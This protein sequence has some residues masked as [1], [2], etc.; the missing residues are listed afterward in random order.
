MITTTERLALLETAQE[1]F[2]MLIAARAELIYTERQ[3]AHPDLSIIKQW[4][5]EQDHFSTQEEALSLGDSVG[6]EHA[7]QVYAPQ[8]KAAFSQVNAA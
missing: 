3:K 4:Q 6:I 5:D 8:A 2:G 1:A 7:L